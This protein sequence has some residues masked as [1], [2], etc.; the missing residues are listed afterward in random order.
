MDKIHQKL[1]IGKTIVKLFLN[2]LSL[3]IGVS[4]IIPIGVIM[5]ITILG[6]FWAFIISSPTSRNNLI[7][8]MFYDP[9]DDFSSLNGSTVLT[10]RA[11]NNKG[12]G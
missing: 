2:L 11:E 8:K 7:K 12:G 4:L 6:I 10:A 9:I 3:C 1:K 5:N